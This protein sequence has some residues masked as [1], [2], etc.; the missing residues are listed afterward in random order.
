M[1]CRINPG[2]APRLGTFLGSSKLAISERHGLLQCGVPRITSV[3][4]LYAVPK[5]L[6]ELTALRGTRYVSE[7]LRFLA[8]FEIK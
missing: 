5:L 8:R 4:P 7:I 6:Y 3:K 1:Q 2:W